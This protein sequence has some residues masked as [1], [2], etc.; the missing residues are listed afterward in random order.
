MVYFLFFVILIILGF[1]CYYLNLHYNREGRLI[2]KLSGPRHIPIF[3][4]MFELHTTPTEINAKLRY[5]SEIYKPIYKF[6]LGFKPLILISHPDDLE[7]LLT[8]SKHINKQYAYECF[9]PWLGTGLLTSVGE[10]WHRRRKILSKAFHFNI[11]KKY[12]DITNV[13]AQKLVSKTKLEGKETK[14]NLLQFCSTHTLNIICETAM[15]VSLDNDN[16]AKIYKNSIYKIGDIIIYRL[17]RPYITDWMLPFMPKFNKEYK[18]VLHNLN[19]FTHN[20]VQERRKYHEKTNYVFLDKIYEDEVAESKSD[21]TYS[22]QRK[23]LSMLDLLLETERSGG[24]NEEGIKEEVATFIFEGH[25]TTAMGLCFAILLLAQNEEAQNIAR[26]EVED[27]LRPKDG[28]L[29]ISD[30]QKMN[31]LERCIKETL[32]IF[33]SVPS[34][35]RYLLEDVHLKHTTIPRNTNVIINFIDAHR[36]PEFWPEPEKFDP[37]RFLPDQI[38]SRHPFAYVPFSAGPRNCIGQKFAM[39]E[40]KS[41][42]ANILY[43]FY[44]EPIDYICDFELYQDIVIRPD[45]PIHTKF[46]QID[47]K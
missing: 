32:R 27:I 38:K 20:I 1:W 5:W 16:T 36:N 11:L 34:I 35:T 41:L 43:N 10:K 42:L 29:D 14:Q 46:I 23:K 18:E 25:D 22:V 33:P 31:Y 19:S 30:L 37:D 4:S 8:N 21:E 13:H 47:R 7:I 26:N 24:I 12:M 39:L 6:W 9:G 44:L 3:G 28:K 40:L 15:G 2:N 45:K 17:L